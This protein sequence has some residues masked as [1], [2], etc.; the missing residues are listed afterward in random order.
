MNDQERLEY[1]EAMIAMDMEARNAFM[2]KRGT[3]SDEDQ[4]T[5]LELMKDLSNASQEESTTSEE[6]TGEQEATTE[7]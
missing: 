3:P 5:I 4:A 1:A 2:A 7:G 6:V